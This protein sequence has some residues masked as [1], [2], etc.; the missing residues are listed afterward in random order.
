MR[1]GLI[2]GLA[3]SAVSGSPAFAADTHTLTVTGHGE[4]RSAPDLVLLSVGVTATAAT[5]AGALEANTTHMK[6]VFTSLR[7]LGIADKNIQ[8]LNFSVTPQ[9]ANSNNA[10]A[11]LTGYR[12][13][14]EVSVRLEDIAKLGALLDTLVGAGANQMNDVRFDISDPAP[15][16]EKARAQAIAD[17]RVQAETYAKAAALTLGPILSISQAGSEVRPLRMAAPM[18][19]AAKPV[20][21]AAGEQSVSA[22]VTVVWEIR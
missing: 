15:L 4:A 9:Y 18:I 21:V 3:L 2:F 12:V 8:T 19:F 6:M 13:N 22:D 17:A 16:L 7:N 10:P 5:A 20:P 14:N 11:R 1:N